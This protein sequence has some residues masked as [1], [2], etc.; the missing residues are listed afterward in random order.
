[1]VTET[2]GVS[3]L[4]WAPATEEWITPCRAIDNMIRQAALKLP[5][6]HPKALIITMTVMIGPSQL[7]CK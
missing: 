5:N 6:V 1:M 2:C 4:S 3:C 7:M